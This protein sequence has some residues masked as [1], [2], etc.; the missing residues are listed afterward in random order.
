MSGA[1]FVTR[2]ILPPT[3]PP[4]VTPVPPVVMPLSTALGPFKTSTRSMKFAAD[5][6][7]RRDP[8]QAVQA[9]IAAVIVEAADE[10]AVRATACRLNDA[11]RG[12][13]RKNVA[14]GPRLLILNQLRRVTGLIERRIHHAA[15]AENSQAAARCHLSTSIGSRRRTESSSRRRHI[16]HRLDPA[17]RRRSDTALHAR[18]G[19]LRSRCRGSCSLLPWRRPR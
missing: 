15:I 2:L 17:R 13:V 8:I 9:E 12:I 5:G 11:D 1:C 18:R 14:D 19:R 10:E 16:R 7:V 4:L 6:I 3:A